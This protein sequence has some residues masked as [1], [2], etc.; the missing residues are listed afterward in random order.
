MKPEIIALIGALGG[1][2]IGTVGNVVISWLMKKYEYKHELK[3]LIMS[4]GLEEFKESLAY[5]KARAGRSTIS[6]PG[7]FMIYYSLIA[8]LIG[9]GDLSEEKV[10]STMEKWEKVSKVLKQHNQY[11]AKTEPQDKT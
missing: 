8:T 9:E 6:P 4:S 7:D 5:A 11:E 1:V 10:K 3:K 2:L